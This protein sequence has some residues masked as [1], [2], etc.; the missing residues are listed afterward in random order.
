MPWERWASGSSCPMPSTACR[1]KRTSKLTSGTFSCS[2]AT[3]WSTLCLERLRR[4]QSS[5][6]C[7][8]WGSLSGCLTRPCAQEHL[9][10]ARATCILR[11]HVLRIASASEC[12]GAVCHITNCFV[13]PISAVMPV[14]CGVLQVRVRMEVLSRDPPATCA[15][16]VQDALSQSAAAVV[17][18]QRVKQMVSHAYHDALFMA[19]RVPTGMLFIPCAKGWSHRPDEFASE[20]DIATGVRVLAG[21][22]MQLAGVAE[23]GVSAREDL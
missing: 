16:N 14:P 6:R 19:H 12:T 18:S 17:G 15:Q 3:M 1:K 4:L 9:P 8:R 5:A 10:L 13:C 7:G 20:A 2:G 22:L 23:E 11:I 21:A